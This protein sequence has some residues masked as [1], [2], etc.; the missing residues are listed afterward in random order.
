MSRKTQIIITL[1]TVLA[2][3]V[4]IF[5][6]LPTQGYSTD[7]SEI[8]QGEPAVVLGFQ[9]HSPQGIAAM[10]QLNKVRN[11]YDGTRFL[12]ADLLTDEGEALAQTYDARDG[13]MAIFD[14]DGVHISSHPVPDNET[15]LRELIDRAFG[16]R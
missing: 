9:N 7:L 1:V 2:A 3:S 5:S 11:S 16:D 13:H 12:V 10:D 6:Q 4:L 8:G 14:G 15:D